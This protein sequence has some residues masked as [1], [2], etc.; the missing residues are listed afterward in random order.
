MPR[1]P[2]RHNSALPIHRSIGKGPAMDIVRTEPR[3][4][5]PVIALPVRMHSNRVIQP[6]DVPPGTPLPDRA[7]TNRAAASYDPASYDPGPLARVL[8]AMQAAGIC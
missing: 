1:D 5:A 6:V 8:M 4:L 7:E 2:D 3:D